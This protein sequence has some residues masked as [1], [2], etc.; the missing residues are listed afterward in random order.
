MAAQRQLLDELGGE[1]REVVGNDVASALVDLAR[2]ENATQIVLGATA[3]SRWQ[4]AVQR[5]GH[6]P[7]DPA[8]RS[9][10]RARDLADPPTPTRTAPPAPRVRPV[11][12]PLSP[13]RQ[14]WGWVIAALGLPLITVVV[15]QH[16]R[17]VRA[18]R[19]CCCCTSC[20]R[21][22][23]PW[24]AACCRPSSPSSAGSCSPTGSS[25]RRYYQFTIAEGENLLA[26]VVY[27]VAAGIV[28][29]LVD[30]VGRSRMRAARAQAEAEALAALAGALARPGSVAEML[31]QLRS[32]FGLRGGRCSLAT[33]QRGWQAR[34][35]SGVD[36]P[37][38]PS[39]ADVSRDVGGDVVLALAGGPLSTR[40]PAR[41]Q[42]V[43]RPGRRR[44]RARAA[45]APRPPR[46]PTWPPPTRCAASL[47]QAVS[48]DLRTPLASIKASISSLRQRDIDWPPDDVDEFQRDDRGGDRP[49]HRPRRQPARHEPA[50]GVGAR[51]RPAPDRRRGDRAVAALASLGAAAAA[52]STSTCPSRCPTSRPTPRCST[53]ARQPRRQR[54]AARAAG[55]RRRGSTAGTVAATAT[56]WST[57]ASSTAARHPARRPRARVPA[58]P[59]ARRPP[60][61]R[62]G[63]R[64]RAGH[65]PRLR[66]GDGRRAD[67]RRHARR[68]R[69]RW[70][71]ACRPG[72]DPE[73][74]A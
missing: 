50:A 39:S 46:P 74:P 45:A 2:A 61:R 57:S 51:R 64:P 21:W 37:S 67:D 8:V 72:A 20:W 30:R 59:A 23:S 71:S 18:D 63:R 33:G 68:R 3:R 65:R 6:Q 29:V 19:A 13:R 1:Y 4:R 73:Q 69:R 12:T 48:H 32:T 56:A 24:S 9:D 10:R 58:V 49:A 14:L 38:T 40:G 43:R 5:L 47:L 31:G 28:A 22:S 26:L 44:R 60:G 27:V 53:G 16:A 17:H 15:R 7:R 55:T 54:R 70:S 36:P 62:N 11:L 34:R 41:A 52:A 25:R 35:R 42:R 66:R